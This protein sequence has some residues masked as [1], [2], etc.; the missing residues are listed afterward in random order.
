MPDKIYG[1]NLGSWLVL[2]SWMLPAEWLAMG[3]Q[4]CSDCS[5]C[6]ATEFAFAQAYPDTVDQKFEQHW[7]SWFTQDDVDQIAAAGINT[8]RIPLG[9]WIIEPL[10]NRTSEFYPRG[11]IKQLQR[12]LSQLQAAGIVAILDHHAL[13]GVQTAGQMFTGHCTNDVEFYTEY[14]YHR[15]LIWT[16]VMTALSHLDPNFGSVFAIEA[17]NEPIMDAT[18]TP[19]Y[20]TFQANFVKVVRAVEL[21]LGIPVPGI[22]LDVPVNTSNFTYALGDVTNATTLTEIFNDEVK[23]ALEDAIPILAEIAIELAIPT[24]FNFEL[25]EAPC[26]SNPEPLVTN[27]MDVNWQFNNPPNPA[28]AAIG[29]Q[30]YDNHLY[31]SFGG[32]AD[33]NPDAYLT[34]ICNLQRVQNDAA[35]GDSPLWFGEWGL[36]TQF[37]ATDDFLFKW[38]DA[39]KLA[40][41][42]GAGWIFWNFKVEI[43]QL[44]GDL[45]RQWSYLEGLRLGYL[46]Q[47][48]SQVHDSNVCDPYRNNGTSTS[49]GTG[50]SASTSTSAGI[51]TSA[52]D[53]TPTSNGTLV[54]KRHGHKRQRIH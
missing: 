28:A 21:I 52:S 23:S 46:T 8:V 43:S 42:Q 1:V 6:I 44:A 47:D 25:E 4:S 38:A 5:Q 51:S 36:P 2:E 41:S 24:I 31:Y 33:P 14:N 11:G 45:A 7:E 27:F 50:T 12:G 37:N 26:H 40:Y 32:V 49:T 16:A 35:V 19:G 39:Q 20:G 18:Q 13:P 54:R 29:P 9:Y 10:V 22:Q 3:G 30:G 53:S 48:P 34:S 15:A 17:V